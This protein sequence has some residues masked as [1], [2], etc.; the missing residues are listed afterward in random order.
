MVKKIVLIS[1]TAS[2]LF[3]GGAGLVH[4][5]IE[6]HEIDIGS[7]SSIIGKSQNWLVFSDQKNK[8]ENLY[9][10]DTNDF[11][12]EPV[13]MDNNVQ[14]FFASMTYMITFGNDLIFFDPRN[15]ELFS[16]NIQKKE[17]NW[18]T[19]VYKPGEYYLGDWTLPVLKDGKL[20]L[21]I[22]EKMM[23]IDA[24]TGKIEQPKGGMNPSIFHRLDYTLNVEYGN[25]IFSYNDFA[26]HSYDIAKKRYTWYL[27][28]NDLETKF[29][30]YS[31][32]GTFFWNGYLYVLF[33]SVYGCTGKV[34]Q[35]AKIN[36]NTGKVE[37]KR[38]SIPAFGAWVYN[39]YAYVFQEFYSCG[40][41]FIQK[42][43]LKDLSSEKIPA[44]DMFYPLGIANGKLVYC[45]KDS[46]NICDTDGK[47]IESV[48]L[49][50]ITSQN[51]RLFD[52]TVYYV[53]G[54]KLKWF[55]IPATSDN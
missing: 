46:V 39:D 45:T 26:M 10:I 24:K 30:N 51:C 28:V 49:G 21:K 47:T 18:T 9:M 5:K 50:E 42:F 52:N 17:C 38:Q 25:K 7:G 19:Q 40:D 54:S 48:K 27:S 32:N 34:N 4:A 15:V 55:E 53:N 6:V 33:V 41:K 36:P 12:R 35:L 3:W 43:N 31:Q 22:D 20:Y 23:I 16:Y 29:L 44:N 14:Y 8:Q 13:D 37:E 11:E 2:M 1:L